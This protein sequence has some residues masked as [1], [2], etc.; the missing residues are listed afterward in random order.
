MHIVV[1]F[2]EHKMGRWVFAMQKVFARS[3][4]AIPIPLVVATGTTVIAAAPASAPTRTAE[5]TPS[6]ITGTEAIEGTRHVVLRSP[7]R[8]QEPTEPWITPTSMTLELA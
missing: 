5:R 2:R 4:A 3:I 1:R 6:R 8:G 7:A